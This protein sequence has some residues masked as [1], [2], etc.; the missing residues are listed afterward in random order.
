MTI[1]NFLIEYDAIRSKNFFTNGDTINGRIILEVSKETQV[2]S[3]IFIAQGR[4][5][6]RWYENHGQNQHRVFWSNEKYYDVQHHILREARNNGNVS[7]SYN[8]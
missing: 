8:H 6:V 7:N 2:Q 1:Q 5:H 3:L 4:A